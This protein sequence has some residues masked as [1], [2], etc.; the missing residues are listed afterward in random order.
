MHEAGLSTQTCRRATYDRPFRHFERTEPD[1]LEVG[2][3]RNILASVRIR[4]RVMLSLDMPS[5]L[6]RGELAGLIWGDFDFENLT[7]A[8]VRSLVDQHVGKCKTEVSKKLMH[9]DPYTAADLLAWYRE[10][11][12]K[13]PSD[14]VWLRTPTELAQGAASSRCG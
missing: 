11:L 13:A 12:Y 9:L 7:V 4:E 10:T 5:G 6:R 1:V 3:M 14:Y 2:E 8:I